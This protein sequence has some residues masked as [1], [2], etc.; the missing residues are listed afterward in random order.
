MRRLA[1]MVAA[2]C[3]PG[4]ITTEGS[5][6]ERGMKAASFQLNCPEEKLTLRTMRRREGLSCEGSEV[7]VSG[8]GRI[9]SVTY[10]C[11]V[12]GEWNLKTKPQ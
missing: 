12:D 1:I 10:V 9:V 5:F 2:L 7:A 11:D 6:R 4:C 3:L 8:C